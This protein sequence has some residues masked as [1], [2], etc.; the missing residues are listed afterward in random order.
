MTAI[1]RPTPETLH[2]EAERKKK[3]GLPPDSYRPSTS[4]SCA[5]F[6]C[7]KAGV[8]VRTSYFMG[9]HGPTVGFYGA[10]ADHSIDE[11]ATCA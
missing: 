3:L 10:C 1:W 5:T 4:Y 11:K 6:P 2:L 7:G 8:Q 9:P